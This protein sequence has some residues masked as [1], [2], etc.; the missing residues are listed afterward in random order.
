VDSPGIVHLAAIS[1]VSVMKLGRFH[2]LHF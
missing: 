1:L 2:Y